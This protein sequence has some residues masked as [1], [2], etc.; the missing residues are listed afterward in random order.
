VFRIIKRQ[1]GYTKV[2]YRGSAKNAA[3]V[4]TLIGLANCMRCAAGWQRHDTPTASAM[5]KR[6]TDAPRYRSECQG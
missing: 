2:R 1:F 3:Q 6:P 4:M 5:P